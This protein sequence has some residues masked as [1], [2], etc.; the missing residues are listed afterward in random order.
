MGSDVS[1][2]ES[3]PSVL[4]KRKRQKKSN[5]EFSLLLNLELPRRFESHTMYI[6]PLPIMVIILLEELFLLWLRRIPSSS[7]GVGV[8]LFKN[9]NN[10]TSITGQNNNNN[11]TRSMARQAVRRQA[12]TTCDRNRFTTTIYIS[13][14]I[15]KRRLFV[16]SVLFTPS[17]Q[18]RQRKETMMKNSSNSRSSIILRETCQHGDVT[19]PRRGTTTE[20]SDQDYGTSGRIISFIST[21][22]YC[23]SLLFVE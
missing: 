18:L 23:S 16:L 15:V 14:M 22:Y 5:L 10:S 11:N 6:I 7:S 20:E 19:Y 1:S 9:Y 4:L 21:V 12:R 13:I 17:P 8:S 2:T 3:R